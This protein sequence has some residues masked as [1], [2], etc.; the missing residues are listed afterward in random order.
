M[1]KSLLA[2]I[3]TRMQVVVDKMVVNYEFLKKVGSAKYLVI[4]PGWM[5]TSGEWQNI[6]QEFSNDYNVVVLDFPGFG[7][8]P[9]ATAN[10]D[11]Y[12]Y[13]NFTEK[14]LTKLGIRKCILLGHSFG[15]RV[16]TV[17]AAKTSLADKLVLV[18]SAGLDTKNLWITTK[19]APVD[20]IKPILPLIPGKV[21]LKLRALL[22]SQDYK[23]AGSMRNT[24][25][26]VVNQNLRYLL[27]QI[28]VPVFVIWGDKDNQLGVDETKIYKEEIPSSV[29]RIVWGS[30]HSPHLEKA[31]KFTEILKEFLC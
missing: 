24:L 5:R 15:G 4:L 18:D 30:G 6:A 31:E 19:Q 3:I 25:I 9:K 8:T 17:L 7:I 20:L 13:A 14:F 22:G 1:T 2:Y 11:T 28:H 29:V 26:K 23:S 10:L 21:A 27:K 16:A 12:D